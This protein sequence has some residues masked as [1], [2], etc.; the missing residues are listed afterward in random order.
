MEDELDIALDFA[1]LSLQGHAQENAESSDD[2]E[3][4][5]IQ[6]EQKKWKYKKKQKK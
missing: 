2:E 3:A 1:E 6:G 5:E 4:M